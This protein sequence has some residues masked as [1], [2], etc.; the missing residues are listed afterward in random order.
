MRLVLTLILCLTA[1]SAYLVEGA[2]P[3]E[4]QA[5]GFA[6]TSPD[7]PAGGQIP[8]QFTCQGKDQ[9]EDISPQLFWMGA[10]G[11]TKGYALTLTDPDAPSGEFTHWVVYDLPA[12]SLGIPRGGPLPAG[13][14]E[15]ANSF[16]KEAYGGPCPPGGEHRYIFTLYALDTPGL[17]G[18][19]D[20]AE[21]LSRLKGHIL[22]KAELMGLYRRH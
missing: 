2:V 20:K 15:A 17:G 18:I 19:A 16:G 1:A 7:F 11:G 13:A 6:L 10:P 14:K 9:G 5:V 22:G 4:A 3:A 8:A 12:K 21:L